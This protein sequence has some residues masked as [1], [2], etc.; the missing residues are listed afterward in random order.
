LPVGVP[1]RRF[2][3]ATTRAGPT[4][5]W[6]PA[7]GDAAVYVAFMA[8]VLGLVFGARLGGEDELQSWIG[9]LIG[10]A[11]GAL[12]VG[13]AGVIVCICGAGL[14]AWGAIGD[15]EGPLELSA[16]EKELMLPIG[17]YGTGGRGAAIALIG[18]YLIVS[19]IHGDPRQAH[20][21][22]GILQEMRSLALGAAITGAFAL[23]FIGSAILDFV[24]AS[25]RRFNLR[26]P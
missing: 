20:E 17:R 11:F 16:L 4:G 12:L 9:W 26:D 19:A 8:S 15:I 3:A 6:W 7:L 2:T 10:G 25:F 24:V 23:A 18:F 22:G 13:L 21:L 5:S 14:I 1:R